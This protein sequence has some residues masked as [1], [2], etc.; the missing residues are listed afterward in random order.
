M[1]QIFSK[2]YAAHALGRPRIK[3]GEEHV[4]GPTLYTYKFMRL[5]GHLFI[6]P[7]FRLSLRGRHDRGN[8]NKQSIRLVIR[9]LPRCARKDKRSID[10]A[11]LTLKGLKRGP[12]TYEV[13]LRH[14]RDFVSLELNDE[15]GEVYS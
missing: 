14:A 8:L 1:N 5:N 4:R 11:P 13:Y 12:W 7:A 6:N 2:A 15:T 9:R 3:S 10:R